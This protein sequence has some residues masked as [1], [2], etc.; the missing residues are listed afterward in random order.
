MSTVKG[1]ISFILERKSDDIDSK[2]LVEL[3]S[4]YSVHL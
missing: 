2:V 3:E 1:E 4:L